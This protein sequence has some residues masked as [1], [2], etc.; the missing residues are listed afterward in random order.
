MGMIYVPNRKVWSNLKP[1]FPVEIDDEN[2]IAQTLVF[3]IP[4]TEGE[5]G[6]VDLVVG[7]I[8]A[9]VGS[10]PPWGVGQHGRVAAGNAIGSAWYP[11]DTRMEFPTGWWA[12]FGNVA[13]TQP[14]QYA[15]PFGKTFSNGTASPYVSYDFEFNRGGSGA[16]NASAAASVG[17]T[18]Y[19]AAGTV[20]V[21]RD[22]VFVG[23]FDGSNLHFYQDGV[24]IGSNANAGVLTYDTS[25]SGNLIL[26]GSSSV[27]AANQFAGDIYWCAAGNRPLSANQIRSLSQNPFQLV[28]PKRR[29]LWL[30]YSATTGDTATGSAITPLTANGAAQSKQ[31]ATG[32][33]TLSVLAAATAAALVGAQ[34]AAAITPSA[35][36]TQRATNPAVT[37]SATQTSAAG[38]ANASQAAQ[39]NATVQPGADATAQASQQAIGGAT[40]VPTASG[41]VAIAGLNTAVGGATIIPSASGRAQASQTAVGSATVRPSLQASAQASNSAHASGST[42]YSVTGTLSTT[43]PAA[44]IGRIVPQAAG[45]WAAWQSAAGVSLIEPSAS[46]AVRAGNAYATNPQFYL[47]MPARAFTVAMA[48]RTFYAAMPARSFY[49]QDDASMPAQPFPDAMDPAEVQVLT[50]DGTPDLASGETL[51]SLAGSL[52]VE[53]VRGTDTQAASRFGT[54]LINVTQIAA[55]PPTIQTA[56]AAGKGLQIA[57]TQPQDGCWY[58]FRQPCLTSAGRIVT[59]KGILQVTSS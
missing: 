36:G 29:K 31:Q 22:S 7:R 1:D 11:R 14:N 30:A 12:F 10:Y 9:P 6:S 54:P 46:A 50:I 34:I 35:A 38:T 45:T 56:V 18:N 59:L 40:I 8:P 25:S 58:L 49:L 44:V 51:S 16:N 52:I 32:S 15:R 47:Q 27:T 39:A 17:G 41:A 24:L 26:A 33:A 23:T 3:Y 2:T 21:G 20:T 55:D 4:L 42:G 53:M 28:R 37:A 43:V 19:S 48:A 57:A 13:A 5:G